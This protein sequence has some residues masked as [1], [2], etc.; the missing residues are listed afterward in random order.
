MLLSSAGRAAGCCFLAREMWE[1]RGCQAWWLAR[2]LE[3]QADTRCPRPSVTHQ[4]LPSR[5][6]RADCGVRPHHVGGVRTASPRGDTS[7]PFS[8]FSEAGGTQ[9]DGRSPARMPS[10]PRPRTALRGSASRAGRTR[11]HSH[12]GRAFRPQGLRNFLESGSEIRQW[13]FRLKNCDGFSTSGLR[14][15]LPHRG[16][17]G[18]LHSTLA[19]LSFLAGV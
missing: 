5:E 18:R 14:E 10:G 12:P 13:K 15:L 11:Q 8:L 4:R 2:R 7:E 19:Q 3:S 1:E 6:P 17:R 16:S 9:R